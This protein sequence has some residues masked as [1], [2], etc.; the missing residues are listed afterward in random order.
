MFIEENIN[1]TFAK[2]QELT[3]YAYE[4]PKG[5]A[6]KLLPINF[7]H[8]IREEISQD[9]KRYQSFPRL[10]QF[11]ETDSIKNIGFKIFKDL[12]ETLRDI[13]YMQPNFQ[14]LLD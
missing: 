14:T 13:M 4:C 2:N 5:G 6:D 8:L 12:K 10:V 7:V 1:L 3:A 11:S 9:K